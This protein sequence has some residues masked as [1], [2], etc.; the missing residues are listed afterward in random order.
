MDNGKDYRCRDFA[1]GKKKYRLEVDTL[2]ASA[3]TMELGIEARFALPYNG[4]TKPIERDFREIKDNFNRYL[5][6]YRGGHVRERPER[7]KKE[8][9]A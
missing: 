7:L 9:Q 1:G 6:G 3:L 2:R 5:L 8:I 4:R